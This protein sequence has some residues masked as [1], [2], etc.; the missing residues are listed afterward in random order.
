MTGE[1]CHVWS[2]TLF[3]SQSQCGLALQIKKVGK[4][5]VK[6]VGKVERTGM[7]ILNNI[8]EIKIYL[9]LVLFVNLL[10]IKF[11]LISLI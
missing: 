7:S 6:Y 2:A 3:S 1:V 10:G 8:L 5:M 11:Y 4:G 9:F